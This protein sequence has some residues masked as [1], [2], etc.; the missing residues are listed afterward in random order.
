MAG[1][2]GLL[3][4]KPRVRPFEWWPDEGVAWD[5]GPWEVATDRDLVAEN[6]SYDVEMVHVFEIKHLDRGRAL[7]PNARA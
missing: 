1:P 4:G 6:A 5:I 7:R 2:L 3:E